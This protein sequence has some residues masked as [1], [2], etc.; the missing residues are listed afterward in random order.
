MLMARSFE[1]E[2]HCMGRISN[3]DSDDPHHA[4]ARHLPI[5]S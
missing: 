4:V 2:P 5:T 3:L 1:T